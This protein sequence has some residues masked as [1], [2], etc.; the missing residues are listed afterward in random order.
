MLSIYNCGSGTY[1]YMNGLLQNLLKSRAMQA[2]W[3]RATS[4]ATIPHH[5]KPVKLSWT[6]QFYSALSV[7][8]HASVW[9]MPWEYQH[10]FCISLKLSGQIVTSGCHLKIL[11]H[12][13]VINYNDIRLAL[14]GNHKTC[15]SLLKNIFFEDQSKGIC[16]LCGMTLKNH[17]TPVTGGLLPNWKKE[18]ADHPTT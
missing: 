11:K 9:A 4:H 13:H 3:G 1:M 15:F 5:S 14:H 18:S 10:A 8:C 16:R 7:W 6:Q 2:I 12:F 17:V